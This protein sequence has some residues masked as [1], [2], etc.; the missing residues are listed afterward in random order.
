[1]QMLFTFQVNWIKMEDFRNLAQIGILADVCLFG[2]PNFMKLQCGTVTG[3]VTSISENFL[4]EWFGLEASGQIN[5]QTQKHTETHKRR[6]STYLSKFFF[7]NCQVTN[8]P[9]CNNLSESFGKGKNQGGS[10]CL[11]IMGAMRLV[12]LGQSSNLEIFHS[13]RC[14][15]LSSNEGERHPVEK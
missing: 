10:L 11:V 1:M 12:R 6:R 2:R 4:V 8:G 15:R 9:K 5:K 14:K 3:S 13:G 7:L